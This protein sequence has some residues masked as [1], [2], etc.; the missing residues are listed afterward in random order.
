M[1]EYK[2]ERVHRIILKISGE[3]LAGPK[4]FGFDYD[5]INRITDEL[6]ALKEYGVSIGVVL[7]GGNFFRGGIDSE[8]LVSRVTGDSIGMLATIQN[9]LVLSDMLNKKN[10]STEVFSSIQIDKIA[11]FYTPNDAENAFQ[12]GKICF[13]C[14]GTG[15]PFFTTDTAA[16]LRAIELNADI[17]LKGTKVDGV[18]T[19]DPAKDSSAEFITSIS[20]FEINR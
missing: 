17:V 7:G 16:V 12:D 10:Y 13:F 14:A 5:T 2:P 9:S 20:F 3:F 15:N 6:L 11:K 4:N 18:Y 19:A 1:I 8:N